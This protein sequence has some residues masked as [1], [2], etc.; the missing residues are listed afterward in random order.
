MTSGNSSLAGLYARK[1]R[2]T[3]ELSMNLERTFAEWSALRGSPVEAQKVVADAS[4][5]F[6][7]LDDNGMRWLQVSLTDEKRK[8]FAAA[9]LVGAPAISENLY[10][11]LLHAAVYET[12]PLRVQAFMEPLVKAFTVKRVYQNLIDYIEKGTDFEKAGAV[13]AL[14]WVGERKSSGESGRHRPDMGM[15]SL[16]DYRRMLYMNTFINNHDLDVR[17]SIITYVDMDPFTANAPMK[18]L[19][20]KVTKLARA[21]PDEYIRHRIEVQLGRS[22]SAYSLPARKPIDATESTKKSWWKQLWK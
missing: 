14:H 19:I 13:N 8:F 12:S 5:H 16:D 4:S 15:M 18:E 21:H 6:V 7:E 11:P 17:R 3:L 1:I 10:Q 2:T 9:L 20:E 22:P